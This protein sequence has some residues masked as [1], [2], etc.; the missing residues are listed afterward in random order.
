MRLEERTAPDLPSGLLVLA[1]FRLG[2]SPSSAMPYRVMPYAFRRGRV[3]HDTKVA[4]KV[5]TRPGIVHV[6]VPLGEGLNSRVP[7]YSVRRNVAR[8]PRIGPSQLGWLLVGNH[9]SPWPLPKRS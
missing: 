5:A 8:Q 7:A 4:T 9:Q 6:S 3:F 2:S 1:S